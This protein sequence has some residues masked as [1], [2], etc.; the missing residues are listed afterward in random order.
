MS[1]ARVS[2]LDKKFRLDAES[3]LSALDDDSVIEIM[4]DSNEH[5]YQE[6][7]GEGFSSLG[8]MT[9]REAL[10]FL[11]T[12][13]HSLETTI[14]PENPTI[15]GEVPL[16]G[17][18]IAAAIPPVVPFPT[19]VIRKQATRIY[20]LQD[21]VDSNIL[22][23]VGKDYLEEAIRQR[24]NIVIAGGVG[25]GKTTFANAILQGITELTPHHRVLTLEDTKEL[26][27]EGQYGT[28]MRTSD[29]RSL[30]DLSRLALRYRPDRIIVG[31]VRS[32]DVATN[33][34]KAFSTGSPGGL[35]TVHANSSFDTLMR[36]EEL[37][38][39]VAKQPPRKLLG[40]A[41]D[42]IVYMVRGE[43]AGKRQVK[44]ILEL[45]DFCI[46]TQEYQMTPIL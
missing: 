3:I 4:L 20:S 38:L 28:S 11:G 34:L 9:A 41:I 21:Y 13:A 7:V 27:F 6:R 15:E 39:E 43:T 32:G 10:R 45:Q 36:L 18:R 8:N 19:F 16:Y 42:V 46:R 26:Q 25:S 44:E 5:L 40:R 24:K 29:T 1:G 2:S 35:F 30:L 14:T 31:E 12:I 33:A 22:P 23:E 37:L 17:S